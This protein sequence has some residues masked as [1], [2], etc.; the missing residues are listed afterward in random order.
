MPR[1]NIQQ[2]LDFRIPVPPLAEQ[3]RIVRILDEAMIRIRSGMEIGETI[4]G[5]S[6]NLFHSQLDLAMT[7]VSAQ[8]TPVPLNSLCDPQR[9]ITYGVIK[10]GSHVDD[11]V[12]CLRTSNVRSLWIDTEAMKRIEPSL[13]NEYSRTKLRGGE[14]LVN[15]RG[16]LGGVATVGP[17]MAGWNVSREVAVVPLDLARVEPRFVAAFV[18]SSHGQRWLTG[19]KKGTAYVGINL[20]DLRRLPTPIPDL[21]TQR[22]ISRSLEGFQSAS[23]S[24]EKNESQRLHH[25]EELRVALLH[26]AFSGQL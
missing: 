12:P 9:P 18:A 6:G 20:E 10:L 4:V 26:D 23:E 22:E 13:S 11:G 21:K 25:L 14:V 17:D 24:L 1:A 7:K 5:L 2:L 19:V 15:V 3:E 8:S 16:T